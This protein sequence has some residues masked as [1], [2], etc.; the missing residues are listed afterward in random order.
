M[1]DAAIA[2]IGIAQ[3]PRWMVNAKIKTGTLRLVLEISRLPTYGVHAV[4]PSARQ[5]P[6]KVKM[7]VEF[8]QKELNSALCFLGTRSVIK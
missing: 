2:G 1:K 5:I 3:L 6:V 7:F 8:I 4:F